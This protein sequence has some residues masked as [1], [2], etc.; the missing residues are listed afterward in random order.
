[1]SSLTR[2][3]PGAPGRSVLKKR[4]RTPTKPV[5]EVVAEGLVFPGAPFH[6]DPLD[7]STTHFPNLKVISSLKRTAPEKK[8]LLPVGYN[9]VFSRRM[10]QSM[11]SP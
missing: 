2:A 6:S 3:V 8:Y 9:F 7:R 10:P 5:L 1:M 11:S 4:G